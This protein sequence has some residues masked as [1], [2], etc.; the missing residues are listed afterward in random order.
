M[1]DK[2]QRENPDE[3]PEIIEARADLAVDAAKKYAAQ[4][5]SDEVGGGGSEQPSQ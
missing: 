5:P 2:L 1:M 3:D 4:H